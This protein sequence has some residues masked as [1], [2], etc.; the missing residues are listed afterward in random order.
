MSVDGDRWR[1]H[2]RAVADERPGIV[3]VIKG[4]GYGFG[5]HRLAR[6]AAWLG[7]D[8]AAVGTYPELPGVAARFS[9]DLLVLNPWRPFAAQVDP[10][11]ADRVVHTVGRLEDLQALLDA[12]G[13]QRIVLE[14]MTAMK[15][16]GFSAADLREA[17]ALIA[18]HRG[19][20]G[21]RV[22]GTTIHL[23]LELGDGNHRAAENA[24]TDIVA[25]GLARPD[26]R[27]P[28]T[29]WVSHLAPAAV[30]ALAAAYPEVRFRSRVGTA[31]WL[32]APGAITVTADVLD[33]HPV[34]RGEA[35]G[36]RG[37]TATRSG[38]LVIVS[39]GTGHGIGLE[40]PTG[41]LDLRGRAGTLARGGRD[42]IGQVKSPYII[43]G[44]A[45]SFAEP[46]H[47][48]SSMLF[49][50]SDV[51]APAVGDRIELRVRHTTTLFDAV[52]IS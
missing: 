50:P 22:E 43:A 16:H 26:D 20:P 41:Q 9:G 7:V 19:G 24:M 40:S 34:A 11:I 10:A 8:T 46:P 21:V 2:L 45:R 25:A 35:F 3:P 38:S 44:K 14:R 42:A 28:A 32:G 5:N 52:E 33:V 27:G 15:R 4:N 30:A 1:E 6:R 29:I 36:Y 12:P 37:R 23:P 49:L 18:R 13:R 31:L 47:M 17:T 48:Q 51:P 39:G